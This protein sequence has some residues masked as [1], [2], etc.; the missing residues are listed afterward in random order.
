MTCE[1]CNAETPNPVHAVF[2]QKKVVRWI[3]CEQCCLILIRK[4]K[5]MARKAE[6]AS[7]LTDA[8]ER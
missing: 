8:M 5:S 1:I 6:T 7:V 3:L 4:L 2:T